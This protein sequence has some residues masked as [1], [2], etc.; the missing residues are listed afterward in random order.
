MEKDLSEQEK[1]DGVTETIKHEIIK[2]KMADFFG[3][4]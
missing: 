4:C 2:N 1:D 3:L